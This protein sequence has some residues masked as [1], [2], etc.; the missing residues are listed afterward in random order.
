M[1]DYIALE[2]TK[3]YELDMETVRSIAYH[4]PELEKQLGLFENRVF[5]KNRTYPLDYVRGQFSLLK[6]LKLPEPSLRLARAI[7]RRTIFKNLVMKEIV[8][9]RER[10]K[11]IGL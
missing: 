4:Y 11:T 3:L 2:Q 7:H 10:R 6:P 8:K 5:S 9:G 1:C